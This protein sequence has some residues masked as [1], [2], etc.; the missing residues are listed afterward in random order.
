MEK[1]GFLLLAH[2]P[3][4]PDIAS[5]DFFLFPELWKMLTG[6]AYDDEEDLFSEVQGCLKQLS[7]DGLYHPFKDWF[8]RCYK[9]IVQEEGYVEKNN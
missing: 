1:K 2:P 9:Y 5:C 7:K 3:Y 8:H 4:S 6:V